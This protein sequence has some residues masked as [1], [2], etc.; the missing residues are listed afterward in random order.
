MWR[1]TVVA[2]YLEAF[3]TELARRFKTEKERA[4]LAHSSP[5]AEFIRVGKHG[6]TIVRKDM[7]K[8]PQDVVAAVARDIR[9]L[10]GERSR[11][12]REKENSECVGGLRNPNRVVARSPQLRAVGARLRAAIEKVSLT[13]PSISQRAEDSGTAKAQDLTQASVSP[14]ACPLGRSSGDGLRRWQ[15]VSDKQSFG[16]RSYA[17]RFTSTTLLVRRSAQTGWRGHT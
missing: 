12:V 11:D 2:E 17:C 6:D 9:L 7:V 5:E 15:P 8:K 4:K 14:S 10:G 3:C 1:T 13:D 16:R